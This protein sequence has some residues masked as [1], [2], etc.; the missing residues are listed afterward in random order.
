MAFYGQNSY[1][2]LQLAEVHMLFFADDSKV[3][4]ECKYCS[5]SGFI[6]EILKGN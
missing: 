3:K 5:S 1:F 2:S 4:G 6:R